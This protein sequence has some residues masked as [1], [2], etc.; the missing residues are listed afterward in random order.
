MRTL[1]VIPTYNEHEGLEDLIHAVL[2][3][4]SEA[5]DV[6]IVDDNSPDGTGDI[7]DRLAAETA[8]VHVLHRSGKQGLSTAYIQGFRWGLERDYVAFVEMDADFSHHPSYLPVMLDNLQKYDVAIGSR[9]VKGGATPDWGLMRKIISR[10]G[11]FYARMILGVPITDFTGGFN[12]WKRHVLAT[13]DLDSLFSGGY[14]FQI[15]LKYRAA[16]K[17]FSLGEFPIVFEDRRTGSSKMSLGIVLEAVWRVWEFRFSKGRKASPRSVA[18]GGE[19][20]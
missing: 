17:G 5:V 16:A 6:L 14:S 2:A 8:R 20:D 7:A 18:M 11:S 4:V 9:Y 3:A 13:I 15:E 12:G 1:I 19:E 10:G